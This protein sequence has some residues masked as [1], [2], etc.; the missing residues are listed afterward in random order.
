MNAPNLL[1]FFRLFLT[2]FFIAAVNQGRY[3][4]AL[5][6]FIL[7]GVSDLLD[8]FL[9]RIMKKKPDFGAYLDPIADKTMLV[10]SYV[11]L[12]LHGIV[13]IWVTSVVLTRDLVIVLGFIA[14][15]RLSYE[16]KV[17]PTIWGKLTTGSQILTVVY[18]L[19]SP[20]RDFGLYF[21]YVVTLLTVISGVHY[22]VG[23]FS[24]L[25]RGKRPRAGKEPR[26]VSLTGS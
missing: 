4:L 22:V 3:R 25:A 5:Y 13:P 1:S 2:V 16:V 18:L 26:D 24:A 7:Q 8:G 14:L 21:F 23:G 17:V 11:V 10:S 15:S 9:A 12:Y 20:T 19:W 6:V